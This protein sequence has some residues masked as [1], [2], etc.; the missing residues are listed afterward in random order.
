[1][2]LIL[3]IGPHKTASTAIQ[4]AL[5][6]SRPTLAKAG[7]SYPVRHRRQ[8]GAQIVDFLRQ[9]LTDSP[10]D[11]ALRDI[12]SGQEHV[13]GGWRQLRDDVNSAQSAII[14]AEVL[15]ICTPALAQKLTDELSDTDRRV[16]VCLRRPS[17]A[18]P[19]LY[20]EAVKWRRMLSFEQWTRASL[21]IALK[22]PSVITNLDIP[23]V[24]RVWETVGEVRPVHVDDPNF[25]TEVVKALGI[26][27][28]VTQPFLQRGNERACAARTVAWQRLTSRDR[29][30]Y[31]VF[32]KATR[33]D[34]LVEALPGGG[35]R[36]RLRQEVA[37]MVDAA[38]PLVDGGSPM[39][40][41]HDLEQRLRD[42]RPLTSV[43]MPREEFEYAVRMCSHDFLARL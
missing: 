21:Q 18:I 15:A 40:A 11:L 31:D 26:D 34:A 10:R 4:N 3:H 17:L 38:F 33:P 28:L 37:D 13:V 32:K 35:G 6:A 27:G 5:Y 20:A 14:S 30:P 25:D 41:R 22:D 9:H 2:S 39:A 43:G 12:V 16:L 29:L 42:P 36:L 1:M 7:I 24:V 19:S 8:H 23:G